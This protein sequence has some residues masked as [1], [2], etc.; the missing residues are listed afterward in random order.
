MLLQT[1]QALSNAE[2]FSDDFASQPRMTEDGQFKLPRS[3]DDDYSLDDVEDRTSTGFDS[4]YSGD[5]STIHSSSAVGQE[6]QG[7][8]S[9]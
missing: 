9:F 2:L 7:G 6:F 5:S 3:E 1:S 8:M 4:E